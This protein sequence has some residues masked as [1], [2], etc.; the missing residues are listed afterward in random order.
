MRNRRRED[1]FPGKTSFQRDLV[2]KDCSVWH[3]FL[4]REVRGRLQR[5]SEIFGPRT[6]GW[7]SHAGA[8]AFYGGNPGALWPKRLEKWSPSPRGTAP[9]LGRAA[10]S[11][12]KWLGNAPILCRAKRISGSGT[13]QGHTR[14]SQYIRQPRRSLGPPR[15]STEKTI[16]VWPYPCNPLSRFL[17]FR[18][19]AGALSYSGR[20]WA[21]RPT[22]PA[23]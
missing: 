13:G 16:Q 7:K 3:A 10:R 2:V 11:N 12:Q 20:I 21:E 15:P 5:G 1:S 22:M 18:K 4:D 14:Q 6:P 17:W 9:S 23:S 8:A 19:R